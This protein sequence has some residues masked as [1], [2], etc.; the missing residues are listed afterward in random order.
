MGDGV[1]VPAF[2]Q[3]RDGY[4]AADAL[5]ETAGLADGVH[6][7]AQKFSVGDR[8]GRR[9][10]ALAHRLL[11]FE[12]LDLRS[13]EFT[14][15]G[16]E[17]VVGLDLLAVDEQRGRLGQAVAVFV[18]VAEEFEMALMDRVEFAVLILALE[19]GNPLVDQ[20]RNRRVAA[21]NDEDRGHRDNGR[22]SLEGL[23]VV[24]VKRHRER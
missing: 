5:A 11:T 23:L 21:H 19:A 10:R 2:R 9:A 15:G 12:L 24:R 7:F 1:C 18:E 6:D 20:L 8:L 14:K 3:H 22:P 13:S 17:R 16:V 4:D